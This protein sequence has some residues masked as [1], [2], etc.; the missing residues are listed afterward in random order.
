MVDRFNNFLQNIQVAAKN[1]KTNK[2]REMETDA[3]GEYLVKHPGIFFV[4]HHVLHCLIE[5]L[6]RTV[7]LLHKF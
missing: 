5:L 1:E 2:L 7:R 4:S 6:Q 3:L